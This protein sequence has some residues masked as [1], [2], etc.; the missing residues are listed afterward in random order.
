MFGNGL[1]VE[2]SCSYHKQKIFEIR[3]SHLDHVLSK[4]AENKPRSLLGRPGNEINWI[5]FE[6]TNSRGLELTADRLLVD[7]KS[8]YNKYTPM[9][10]I[11][12]GGMK[13]W[14]A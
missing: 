9:T 3:C 6:I 11:S 4:H 13:S 14:H 8:M 7:I 12:S 2:E 10:N 1:S 5:I